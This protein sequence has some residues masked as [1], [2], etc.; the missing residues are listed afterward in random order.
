MKRLGRAVE[1]EENEL[2][3]EEAEGDI[4]LIAWQEVSTGAFI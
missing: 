4:W 2:V 1:K 3:F